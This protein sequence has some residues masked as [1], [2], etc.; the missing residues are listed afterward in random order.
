MS[1]ALSCKLL[2]TT[3]LMTGEARLLRSHSHALHVQYKMPNPSFQSLYCSCALGVDARKS[4]LLGY[5]CIPCCMVFRWSDIGMSQCPRQQLI[6][7]LGLD[8]TRAVM[9][10]SPIDEGMHMR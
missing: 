2:A 1:W 8:V 5:I 7:S 3:A 9:K 10:P 4:A 6:S